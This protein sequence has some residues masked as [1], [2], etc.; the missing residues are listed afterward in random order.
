V[1]AW[2]NYT[3]YT[4]SGYVSLTAAA[5]SLAP[6]FALSAGPIHGLA[7]RDPSGDVAPTLAAQL[8]NQTAVAGDTVHIYRAGG[9]PRPP[10]TY[11]WSKDGTAIS[12]ATTATLTLTSVFS[13]SVG[14]YTVTITNLLGSVNLQCRHARRPIRT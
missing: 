1:V 11:Q 7:L 3:Y 4:S 10:P 8:A 9:G 13:S 6:V 14:S 12:G 5:S 2:G